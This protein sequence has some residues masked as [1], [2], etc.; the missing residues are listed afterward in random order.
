[1]AP[2]KE[3]I[4]NVSI[5]LF[6]R[7]GYFAT[8]MSDIA[9]ASGIQKSSIY[10]HYANKEDI[11]FDILKS[12]MIDLDS[13]LES[14]VN[15]AKGLEEKLRAV[16]QSHIIFHMDRQKEVLISDSELRGLT[17]DNYKTI[18]D[19]RDKYGKKVE[20]LI[21][22][23]MDERVFSKLDYKVVSYGIITMCTAVSIWFNPSGRLSKEQIAKTYTE[24]I[25]GGLKHGVSRRR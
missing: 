1:M 11:L 21:K 2:M 18:I 23:G 4:K 5:D 14:H 10:Y 25:V 19:L 22:K 7:K 17:K 12:T 9:R 16:I 8:G 3:T 13:S 20:D 6:Y 15:R 24:F